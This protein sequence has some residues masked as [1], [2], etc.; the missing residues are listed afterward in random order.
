MQGKLVDV[1]VSSPDQRTNLLYKVANKSLKNVTKFKYLGMTAINQ[2]CFHEEIQSRLNLEKF[3]LPCSSECF[4]FM[5][6]I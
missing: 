3:I 6:A 5:A 1:E 2:N 4:V